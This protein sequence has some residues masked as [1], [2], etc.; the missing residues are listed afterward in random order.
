MTKLGFRRGFFASGTSEASFTGIENVSLQAWPLRA[1][2]AQEFQV[3]NLLN[4]REC[5]LARRKFMPSPR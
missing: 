1:G 3:K 2:I 4:C 5:L